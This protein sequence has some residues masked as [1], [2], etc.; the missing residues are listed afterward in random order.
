[1]WCGVSDELG[2]LC[3]LAPDLPIDID[4]YVI[5]DD[6]A[7]LAAAA[8]RIRRTD[9]RI[10]FSGWKGFAD[11]SF[12][13]HTAAM[14]EPFTDR[15]D[16]TGTLR[17]DHRHA[18]TMAGA[19]LDLGGGAA[20][21][22][23]GDRANDVVLDVF[24]ALIAEG[25]DPSRLRVEHVSILSKAAIGRM[26]GLGV[27]A[28]VQPAFLASEDWLPK[29]LGEERM[30]LVYPFRSLL[31]A[32]V[33]VVGGSDSPVEMPDPEVGILA[34]V[35]RHGLN[36]AQAIT[37]PEARSLFAPP[38]LPSDRGSWVHLRPSCP[39]SQLEPISRHPLPSPPCLI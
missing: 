15:P 35:D 22:A 34:A 20:I 29:R 36:P 13:G 2:T 27:T 14:Y 5:T 32:G 17:L 38:P 11:G 10:R 21:H 39:I 28:S 18:M 26:A 3:R 19:A 30:G 16:I 9:G 4:V 7:E 8:E 31:E 33:R 37:E 1:M 6:P 23:I 24:D 12:G 25:R